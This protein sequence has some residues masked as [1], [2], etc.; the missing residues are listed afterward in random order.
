[1]IETPLRL[2]TST[3]VHDTVNDFLQH[4]KAPYQTG[5]YVDA[6]QDGFLEAG[7]MSFIPR[8]SRGGKRSAHGVIFGD[9]LF[10]DGSSTA[11]AVKPHEVDSEVSCATDYF[12]NIAARDLELETLKPVGM[13]MGPEGSYSLTK[14]ESALDTLD[15][16]NWET[17]A[18]HDKG[19]NDIMTVWDQVARQTA[20]L[21]SLGGVSHG[22]LAA[23]NIATT[24][25]NGSVFFIDWEKAEV[26]TLPPRDAEMQFAHSWRDMSSLMESMALPRTHLK[27]G[28]NLL[29]GYEDKWQGF[30]ELVFDEYAATR[31][32]F[33]ANPQ[34]QY[35]TSSVLKELENSLRAHLELIL[36]RA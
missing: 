15:N 8:R 35:E 36:P 6:S 28:I 9:L 34:Q 23:R 3:P 5:L 13:I 4:D 11:V 16:V 20:M 30:R 31:M 14:L 10:E 21:H 1:V 25:D 22:D 19:D 26:S 17:A 33:A 12:T 24:P 29:S 27:G 2:D 32:G 7:A 18:K